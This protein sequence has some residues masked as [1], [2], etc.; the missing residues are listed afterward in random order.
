MT[1]MVCIWLTS[2]QIVAENVRA[3]FLF[4][5]KPGNNRGQPLRVPQYGASSIG[6][7]RDASRSLGAQACASSDVVRPNS[8]LV[9]AASLAASMPAAPGE[10]L[11][12]ADHDFERDQ[13]HDDDFQ[14]QRAAG[15]DDVGER[16]G[17]LGHHLELAVE[18]FDPRA[19]L[20]FV[21]QPRIEPLEIRADPTA[22]RACRQ[23]R[24]GRR[25]CAAPEAPRRSASGCR[26][27]CGRTFR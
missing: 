24:P 22:R 5:T 8:T 7:V 15:V 12:D 19:Q 3:W 11:R 27:G 23:S 2:R 26:A 16:I 9:T 18:R 20:V 21:F 4:R 14:P 25:R 10:D 6:A 13:Q 1:V 17:R